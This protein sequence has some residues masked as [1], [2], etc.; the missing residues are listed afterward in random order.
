MI[1]NILFLT[2]LLLSTVSFSQV[3][4]YNE[5]F[6]LGIPANVTIV[7]NDGLTTNSAVSDFSDGWIILA[8]PDNPTDS[9]MGSTSFFEPTGQA[10]RWLI[11]PAI[12]IGAYGNVLY[13]NAKS[14]DP[15]FPDDYMILISRT[16]TAIAS[17]TDTLY[18]V[19][20]ELEDWQ[21]RSVNMSDSGFVSETIHVAFVNNTTDGFKLY[22]D[23]IRVE[24]ED[25]VGLI[26]NNIL[27]ISVYPN[28]TSDIININSEDD[29]DEILIYSIDGQ[30]VL[31]GEGKSID[32]S[33][34]ENG[35]YILVAKNKN[36]TSQVQIVKN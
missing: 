2:S 22:I 36:K 17:F 3:E 18:S 5:D 25:P 12:T 20:N 9:I 27:D 28:P 31:S 11:T 10:N 21:A 23:D 1:K 16:N 33:T 24:K 34:I 13:W 7:D 32:I 19:V 26:E 35:R 14:H 30:L 4:I 15:S 29:F 8:D 6:Q